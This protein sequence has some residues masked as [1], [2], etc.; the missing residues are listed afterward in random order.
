MKTSISLKFYIKMI[1]IF[2]ILSIAMLFAII[3]GSVHISIEECFR[4]ILG[5][6]P[7]V[8]KWVSLDGIKPSHITI[9][10]D[11]RLP[12]ILL[13]L[14]AGMGLSVAGCVYQ[15]IFSNPMADPYLL[16]V[17]SGAALG[18]TIAILLKIPNMML[19]L[20][21]ISIMAFLGAMVVLLIVFN[22]AKNKGKLPNLML[23][24]SGVAIN[25]FIASFIALLMLFNSKQLESVYFWTLGSFKDA[26]EKKI[27]LI[28]IVVFISLVLIFR[29]YMELNM[30]SI[31][32]EQA[33]SLGVPTDKIKK[34]L[35]I[36]SSLMVAIIVAT[37][38]I[39]GFVGLITPHISRLIVGPNHKRLIPF[40]MIF[41]G[42][43]L[44]LSDTV[45]RSVLKN[46]EISVGIITALFGVPFF[47]ILLKR[48]KQKII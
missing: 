39:I 17:S 12:R 41:G 28:A 1:I 26:N 33:H 46:M 21:S 36:V 5:H 48:N 40:S 31:N 9:V 29:Y 7:L 8:N 14:F 23:I 10:M 37:C 13:A 44:V 32:E 25:Y 42:V 11:L 45:A 30:I 6:L 3:F 22:L 38:G 35:L 20:S 18:A 43:F 27:I 4:I 19:S 15:G 24:L 47:F 16:G 34:K 2:V